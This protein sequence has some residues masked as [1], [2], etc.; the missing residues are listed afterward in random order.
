MI[1]FLKIGIKKLRKHEKETRRDTYKTE[2][3]LIVNYRKKC[4][5]GKCIGENGENDNFAL[6]S[7]LRM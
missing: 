2:E 3:V 6:F 5:K 4:L 7:F 1:G